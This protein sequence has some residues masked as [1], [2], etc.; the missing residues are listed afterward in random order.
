MIKNPGKCNPTKKAGMFRLPLHPGLF[1]EK[2]FLLDHFLHSLHAG[3]H[4]F[5][6]EE[7][8]VYFTKP[9]SKVQADHLR[10]AQA[11]VVLGKIIAFG[12]LLGP[13][14][15]ENIIEAQRHGSGVVFQEALF[16][17]RVYPVKGSDISL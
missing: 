17:G 3:A 8:G 10:V 13:A 6:L 15:S 5:S 7:G 9:V 4:I 14:A 12:I 16:N 11:A 1:K 2:F